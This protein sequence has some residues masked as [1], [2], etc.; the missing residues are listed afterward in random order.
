[1]TSAMTELGKGIV[2]AAKFAAATTGFSQEVVRRWAYTY[3]TALD[4]YPGSMTLILTSSE[5]SYRLNGEKLVVIQML[6]FM[7]K[8]FSCLQESTYV[9]MRTERVHRTSRLRC[10]ANGS[11]I[12][13]A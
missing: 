11:V 4:Q 10:F 12:A 6:S 7:T 8:I 2:N 1:M 13:L 9:Q 3:F 5:Q